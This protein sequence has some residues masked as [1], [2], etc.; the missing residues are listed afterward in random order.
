MRSEQYSDEWIHN[1]SNNN[2]NNK[3]KTKPS[4]HCMLQR[5]RFTIQGGSTILTN[6]ETPGKCVHNNQP[7]K[8]LNGSSANN[9]VVF[10]S[11]YSTGLGLFIISFLRCVT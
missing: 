1:N 3:A 5:Q 2:N 9:H 10:I 7:M 11:F 4:W 8:I 6:Y